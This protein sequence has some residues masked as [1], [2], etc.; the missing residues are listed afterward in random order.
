[1]SVDP[2][3]LP[4]GSLIKALLRERSLSMRKLSAQTGIHTATISRIVNG[5]QQPKPDHLHRLSQHLQVPAEQLFRAAGY[6]TGEREE[7]SSSDMDEIVA[8]IYEVLASSQWFDE[9][10][11][12]GRIEQELSKYEQYA[13][14]KEGQQIIHNDFRTKM[15]QVGGAGPFINEL[16]EM[17]RL[18]C[19][20]EVSAEERA[21]LGSGLLYFILST[22][23]IPDY[24]FPF[25]YLDDAIAVHLVLRRLSE[26]KGA[27]SEAED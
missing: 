13:W 27:P 6:P 21:V 2:K 16:S 5:K 9:Q 23:I 7:E 26:I 10:F 17:Y 18:Y 11:T 22:D 3:E 20:G 4:L 14:T 12:V 1:M 19:E 15:E 25:G 24:V 8:I